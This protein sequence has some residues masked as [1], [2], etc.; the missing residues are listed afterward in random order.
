MRTLI[1]GGARSGKSALAQRWALE[2]AMG[3]GLEVCCLVTARATDA[4]MAARIAAHR[5]ERPSGWRTVEAPVRLADALR[6]EA[7]AGRVLVVDCLTLWTANCLWAEQAAA[8]D[9]A[10]WRRERDALLAA[11]R[12]LTGRI[13]LVSNE[14]G[15]GIVPADAGSRL[16]RDEHGWL[17]QAVAAACDQVFLVSAGLPLRLR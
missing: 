3:G 16:F 5:A 13:L 2:Q 14:V 6:S 11:L 1:L 4:E 9:V 12:A 10:R 7:G 17:N 8:P 15:L